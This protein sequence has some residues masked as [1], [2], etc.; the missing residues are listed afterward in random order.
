MLQNKFSYHITSTKTTFFYFFIFVFCCFEFV[1]FAPIFW[2]FRVGILP[3]KFSI[4]NDFGELFIQA[5]TPHREMENIE[6]KQLCTRS[7][8]VFEIQCIWFY[9][10]F[11]HCH[12]TEISQFILAYVFSN[13]MDIAVRFK[14]A[15]VSADTL[16]NDDVCI[17]LSFSNALHLIISTQVRFNSSK[18]FLGKKT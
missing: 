9:Y 15:Y 2:L 7:Q 12:S 17:Y 1:L 14:L 4:L 3:T 18:I 5:N 16:C 11:V 8:I 13:C 6:K 10:F